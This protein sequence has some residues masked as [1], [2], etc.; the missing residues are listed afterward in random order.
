MRT[1][2]VQ[3]L[4]D[5]LQICEQG[6]Y[7]HNGRKVKLKLSPAEMR[8]VRVFLPD[9]IAALAE[10]KDF[11]HVHVIG[12]CGH[13][14]ENMDSFSLAR[15]R[16]EDCGYMF[17]GKDAKEILAVRVLCCFPWKAERREN[18]MN[19]IERFTPTWALMRSL[20]RPR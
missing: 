5:T 11:Q 20:L 3:M 4:T 12:R 19:I 16:Y 18:T 7:L 14:C 1:D 8:S 10:Y 17:T 15:K 2:N 9:E 13:G 6:Y